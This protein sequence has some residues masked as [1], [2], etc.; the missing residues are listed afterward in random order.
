MRA[1]T[2]CLKDLKEHLPALER[3][4]KK[5]GAPGFFLETE[6]HLKGG[7]Q[8]GGFSG[9][10]G[11]GVAVRAVVPRSRRRRN[12]LRLT[13]FRR[14][15]P[16]PRLLDASPDATRTSQ[17]FTQNQY[18]RI[19]NSDN[20]DGVQLQRIGKP[21][22]VC[23]GSRSKLLQEADSLVCLDPG[24]RLKFAIRDDIPIMLV[25][26]AIKLSP[27]EWGNIMQRH[28]RDQ[29]RESRSEHPDARSYLNRTNDWLLLRVFHG[30]C[31]GNRPRH[32]RR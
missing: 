13:Q 9:P 28:S 11:M 2:M 18:P 8:F 3:R 6:P 27:E 26:E 23:P 12:R 24:C 14:H 20:T 4:M 31:P 25:D 19:R 5:L 16:R 10:D 32:R 21:C 7:G 30:D 1:T 15:P 22:S 29:R 17:S